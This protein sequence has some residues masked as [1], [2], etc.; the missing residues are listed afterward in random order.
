MMVGSEVL[1]RG[2]MKAPELC[3][4][5]RSVKAQVAFP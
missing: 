4:I 2:E 1:L 5:I 3:E